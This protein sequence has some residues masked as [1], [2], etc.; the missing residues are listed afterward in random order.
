MTAKPDSFI[1]HELVDVGE[2]DHP[3]N[4]QRLVNP[5]LSWS[6]I[7]CFYVSLA[8]PWNWKSDAI[9]GLKIGGYVLE[10]QL[11]LT[12]LVLVPLYFLLRP[13][14]QSPALR[15]IL[16]VCWIFTI[17]GGFYFVC[18]VFSI[19][20]EH[21]GGT[22]AVVMPMIDLKAWFLLWMMPMTALYIYDR[23]VERW[24]LHFLIA[25]ACYC[26]L[27]L[28]IRAMPYGWGTKFIVI[29]EWDVG[30]IGHLGR[31]AMRNDRLLVL[32]IPLTVAWILDRGFT[33]FPVICLFLYLVQ[34]TN[35]MGRTNM[36]FIAII[37]T[38]ILL[39][40]R[41]LGRTVMVLFMI[42]LVVFITISATPE[43]QRYGLTVRLSNLGEQTKDYVM[44][45]HRSNMIALEQIR[46]S[47]FKI[48]FG[49]GFGT[50]LDLY[51]GADT[52]ILHFVDNLWVTLLLKLGII[53]T[54]IIGGAIIYLCWGTA[55]GRAVSNID[56]T[57]KLW[58]FFMPLLCIRSS[59]LLWSAV[60]GAIWTTLAAGAVLA[61]GR[62]IAYTEQFI[63]TSE[64]AAGETVA[65]QE[66]QTSDEVFV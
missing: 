21:G 3:T 49:A 42:A 48:L 55:R 27:V 31:I 29:G 28:V 40:N 35:S 8:F 39:R 9:F 23:G 58:A 59:F 47:F 6:Y 37:T 17:L 64:Y 61:E 56:R 2:N 44:M 36:G 46:G 10:P 57:F 53:G 15:R 24:L 33:P 25:T 22:Y 45:L 52:A 38:I 34:M 26:T 50:A 60:S 43:H 5:I 7:L 20:S 62:E 41:R 30:G 12:L 16:T 13:R 51:G 14:F 1:G 63:D 4:G 18:S 66:E 19:E 65:N 32:A 11:L 54:M